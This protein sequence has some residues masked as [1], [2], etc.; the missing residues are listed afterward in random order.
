MN[1]AGAYPNQSRGGNGLIKWTDADKSIEN[2][3]LVVWYSVGVTHIP[4]PEEWP[5]MSVSHVGFRLMP[6]G[7]FNRNPALDVPP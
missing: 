5:I 2:E 6:S 1:A 7:F 4:R 3:D